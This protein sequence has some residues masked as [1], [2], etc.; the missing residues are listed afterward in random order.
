MLCAVASQYPCDPNG[1]GGQNSVH[2]SRM[3]MAQLTE[4]VTGSQAGTLMV[5]CDD[6]DHTVLSHVHSCPTIPRCTAPRCAALLAV[7]VVFMNRIFQLP[8]HDHQVEL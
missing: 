6:C 8:C 4:L 1:L 3:A 7:T 2:V 5:A